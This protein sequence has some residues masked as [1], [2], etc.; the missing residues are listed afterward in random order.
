MNASPV[1]GR[2]RKIQEVDNA[3]ERR[4]MEFARSSSPVTVIATEPNSDFDRGCVSSIGQIRRST[5]TFLTS[6]PD[7][8]EPAA[9]L[10]DQ[11]DIQ[12]EMSQKT[13]D[14]LVSACMIFTS[15]R[16]VGAWEF[17]LTDFQHA[18]PI[19]QSTSQLQ[20]FL[21]PTL[22]A[23]GSQDSLRMSSFVDF[24]SNEAE[25]RED[26]NLQMISPKPFD[27]PESRAGSIDM[28]EVRTPCDIVFIAYPSVESL[29][30]SYLHDCSFF[31]PLR[32]TKFSTES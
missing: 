17:I 32:L 22:E 13:L 6:C 10:E 30:G 21:R 11:F 18:T 2:K 29:A 25:E 9:P 7:S 23:E 12:D 24:E 31:A 16:T 20:P 3:G 15:D 8:Q 4:S 28:A 5:S 1:A 26:E 14:R 27:C 19:Q